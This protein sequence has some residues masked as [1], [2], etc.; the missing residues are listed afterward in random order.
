M[1]PRWREDALRLEGAEFLGGF[2][3]YDLWLVI[4]HM[5]RIVWG[6]G[7]D[8]WDTYYSDPQG[9]QD[10]YHKEAGRPQGEDLE[11]VFQYIRLFAPYAAKELRLTWRMNARTAETRSTLNATRLAIGRA[12]S[13][14]TAK[15]V[16][17]VI[18]PSRCTS[19]DTAW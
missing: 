5:L 11:L 2:G 12:S 9:V 16:P 17:S 7:A 14:A 8:K 15:P 4:P 10:F 19:R 18:A 1:E 13:A 3:R 6:I